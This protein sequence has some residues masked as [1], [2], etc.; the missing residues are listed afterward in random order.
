MMPTFRTKRLFL[1]PIE[2]KDAKSYEEH[3]V[4]YEVVQYLG[5]H[6]PWPYPKG[7]VKEFIKGVI[8]PAQGKTLFY[9][10]IFLADEPESMIGGIEIRKIANPDNR[11]FWLG[12]KYWGKGYMTEALI[13]V[14]DY[15]FE[16]LGFEKMVFSNASK[17]PASSRIK[18]KTG[19][20]LIQKAPFSFVN[21]AFTEKEVWELTKADW[22]EFKKSLTK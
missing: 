12:R 1:R 15:A 20:R 16:E 19:A 17:N 22:L 6:V 14:M 5:D 4:D 21:P 8:L 2:I 13:P 7:R 9:W 10:G 18:A 11:G 3:F